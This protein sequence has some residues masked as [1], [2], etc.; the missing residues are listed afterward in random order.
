MRLFA[1]R[2]VRLRVMR[3]GEYAARD[4]TCKRCGLR[5]GWMYEMAMD[6]RQ[7]AKEAQTV[8]E[9]AQ[10]REEAAPEWDVTGV[11]RPVPKEEVLRQAAAAEDRKR[12]IKQEEEEEEMRSPKRERPDGGEEGAEFD[13]GL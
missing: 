4:V 7:R 3:T 11:S 5:L 8:L 6:S 2:E 9:C 10:F 12:R 1:Y 13:F